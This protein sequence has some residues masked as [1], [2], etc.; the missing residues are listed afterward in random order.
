MI[1]SAAN[2]LL[3][4]FKQ[5]QDT[6][7]EEKLKW[8]SGLSLAAEC[9][10]SNLAASLATLAAVVGSTVEPDSE[11]MQRILWGLENQAAITATMLEVS[12]SA[13]DLLQSKRDKAS[14]GGVQ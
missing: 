1:C 14:A 9:E 2:A 7:T 5:T 12:A 3:E 6:L 10:S 4:L 8:L 11:V 13:K